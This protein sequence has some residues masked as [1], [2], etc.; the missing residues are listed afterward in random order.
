VVSALATFDDPAP[1]PAALYVG[2]SFTQVG[3]A[4][5]ANRIA[6]WDGASWSNLNGGANNSVLVLRE[7]LDPTLGATV[8]IAGGAFTS[9][10]GVPASHIARWDGANWTALGSGTNQNVYV[11]TVYDDPSV[12]GGD[13]L[14]AAGVFT[15]AGGITVKCI[16]TWD[17][18]QWHAI[19][20]GLP[21]TIFP[22]VESLTPYDDGGGARL[23]LSASA[24]LWRWDFGSWTALLSSGLGKTAV[25]DDGSGPQLYSTSAVRWNGSVLSSYSSSGAG[26][27]AIHVF[28]NGHS[29]PALFLGGSFWT[30]NGINS[31]CIGRYG[32]PC[33][34][35][36]SYCTAKTNSQGCTPAVGWS[37]DPS[38]GA[39][40]STPFEITASN[41]LNQKSGL[42]FYGVFGRASAAFQGG[43]NCVHSPVRRT[44]LRSSDGNVGPDDCSG[45]YSIDF[46]P[47]IDGTNDALLDIGVTVNAQWWSRDPASP[48]TTGLTD[49]IEF[50]IRP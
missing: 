33:A 23:Y 47:W 30:I 20:A 48:S 7:W 46:T 34:T 37:G 32:D 12:A 43:V 16:A 13:E 15:V 28:D 40:S 21:P 26:S 35:L 6:R 42:L 39:S 27:G 10:G 3:G 2:G 50:E 36:A 4:T 44:P 1:G 49:A 25:F 45:V 22:A 5:P 31:R 19:D 17:G 18:V 29:A 11:L 14:Y 24:K 41:V 8:L 38:I 9:I